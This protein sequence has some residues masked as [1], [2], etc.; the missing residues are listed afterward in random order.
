[1][2]SVFCCWQRNLG[3]V[4]TEPFSSNGRPVLPNCSGFQP[5]CHNIIRVNPPL[6]IFMSCCQEYQL[7]YHTNC[8][9]GSITSD[10]WCG[11]KVFVVIY[12]RKLCNLYNFLL[13]LN[14]RQWLVC[15]TLHLRT[16]ANTTLEPDMR[17]S[18]TDS[19]EEFCN[20]PIITNTVT[21]R[22]FEFIC[23]M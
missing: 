15:R 18:Y 12:F 8:I 20:T 11:L 13:L 14:V 9:S 1:M 21:V 4:F 3:N 17:G 22:N 10:N 23:D 6:Y 5:S 19:C 7:G 2:D 16:L